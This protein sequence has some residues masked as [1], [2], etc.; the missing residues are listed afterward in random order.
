[1]VA[2][3]LLPAVL[4]VATP[5]LVAAHAGCE[6]YVHGQDLFKR[7]EEEEHYTRKLRARFPEVN[8]RVEHGMAKRQAVQSA[9]ATA[10][11]RATGTLTQINVRFRLTKLLS[12]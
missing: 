4:A 2:I 9:P 10:P 5:A 7:T 8:A 6:S 12:H 1:M 3:K 11:I